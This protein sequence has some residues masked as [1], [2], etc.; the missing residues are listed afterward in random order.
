[1]GHSLPHRTYGVLG[2]MIRNW[3]KVTIKKKLKCLLQKVQKKNLCLGKKL[4][5]HTKVEDT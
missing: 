3:R 2:P 1:M 4:R 5:V